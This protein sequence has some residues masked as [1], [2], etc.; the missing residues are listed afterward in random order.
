[1]YRLND[2]D[3][4]RIVKPLFANLASAQPMCVAVL[5]GVYPG[6][7][8]V[9]HPTEP[10]N[11]ILTTFIE[12]ESHGIW[13][14]LAGDPANQAFTKALNEAI[15]ARM[16]VPEKSP[17]LLLT[18]DPDDWGGYLDQVFQPRPPIWL[19]RN[20]F[21]ARKVSFDWRGALPVGFR[22]MQMSQSLRKI[23]ELQLPEDVE[24]SL[25]KWGAITNPQFSDFGF[26][27][28]DHTGP[29]PVICSWA[30]VDFV[31]DG[32]GDIGF[33]TMDTY[34]RRNLGTIAASAA[35]E[36]AFSTGLTQVNWT[37]DSDNPG[38][39]HTAEKLQLERA[40]DYQMAMLV[41]DEKQHNWY[42]QQTCA[43]RSV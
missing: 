4:Y 43:E 33:F 20:R 25:N 42:Y 7:I 17:M 1:M 28:I 39:L 19:L 37:C 9:D 41:M 22:V 24:S 23:N 29:H 14:F 30:T 2:I 13:G 8:Y 11:A 12:S 16:I 26:V 38:S 21:I 31:A 5:T 6:T 15:F 32:M 10:H 3:S 34:R 18:C 40:D 35:L 27:T 36:F